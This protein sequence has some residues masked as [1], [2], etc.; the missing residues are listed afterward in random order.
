M[1]NQNDG[2]G[3]AAMILGVI[4]IIV[5]VWGIIQIR[6]FSTFLHVDFDTGYSVIRRLA[7][8]S[9]ILIGLAYVS[10]LGTAAPYIPAAFI[11]CCVPLLSFWALD[12]NMGLYNPTVYSIFTGT[13]NSTLF[14]RNGVR[15]VWYGTWWAESLFVLIPLGAGVW[16]DVKRRA[17]GYGY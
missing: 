6:D 2:A 15:P 4:G 11:I 7:A 12:F 3:A 8:L 13:D 16:Y 17:G 9:V 14:A 10:M 5:C 1:S